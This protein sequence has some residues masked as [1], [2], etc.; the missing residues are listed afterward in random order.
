[1]IMREDAHKESMEIVSV[2]AVPKNSGELSAGADGRFA[3]A[4]HRNVSPADGVP[5]G[6]VRS[7]RC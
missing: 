6:D 5:P 4:A 2:M 1:M 7:S 3:P